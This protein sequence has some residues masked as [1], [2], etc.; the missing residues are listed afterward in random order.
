MNYSSFDIYAL[1]DNLLHDMDVLII[2]LSSNI[3]NYSNQELHRLLLE[4]Y[5]IFF[6]HRS[7]NGL[8]HGEVYGNIYHLNSFLPTYHSLVDH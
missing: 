2:R 7:G 6:L 4:L 8:L 3:E 1:S 5:Q